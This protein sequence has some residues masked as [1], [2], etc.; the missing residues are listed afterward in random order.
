MK[1]LCGELRPILEALKVILE[2]DFDDVKAAYWLG[3][4][5]AQITSEFGPFEQTRIKLVQKHARKDEGGNLPEIAEGASYEMDDMEAFVAEYNDLAN[6]EIEIKYN[7]ISI[8]RLAG[9]KG[10]IGADIANLSKLL[11][12]EE[13]ENVESAEIKVVN[14]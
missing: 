11:K 5:Q 7:P 6:Q 8:D 14:N 1:L 3:R 13:N 10:I 12:D 4:A 9:V 2:K